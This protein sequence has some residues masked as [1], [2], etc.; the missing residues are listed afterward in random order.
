MDKITVK[1]IVETCGIN[2]N[3]F[4]YYYKD[5]Y[6]L[7]DDIF[8]LETERIISEKNQFE[9]WTEELSSIVQ[10]A[11]DNKKAIA[12]LDENGIVETFDSTLAAVKSGYKNVSK[13][14]K[15]GIKCKGFYFKY[16]ED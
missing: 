10:I 16:L 15:F 3:T 4:Y 7:I 11:M 1:D 2:R 12:R 8:K 9:T 14:L 5:V 13:A 6:D